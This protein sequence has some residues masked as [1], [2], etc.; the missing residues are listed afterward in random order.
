MHDNS[1]GVDGGYDREEVEEKREET[2]R[3]S[4]G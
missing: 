1:E 3:Y 2:K 4:D